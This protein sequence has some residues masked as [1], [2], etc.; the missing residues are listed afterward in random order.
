MVCAAVAAAAAIYDTETTG[1]KQ[2]LSNSIRASPILY[3]ASF[4]SQ[5]QRFRGPHEV[6]DLVYDTDK[7]AY[8]ASHADCCT[9]CSRCCHTASCIVRIIV[10]ARRRDAYGVARRRW[11]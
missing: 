8:L 7:G 3:R 9:A 11:L 10:C 6:H 5:T 2:T 1:P 4:Q